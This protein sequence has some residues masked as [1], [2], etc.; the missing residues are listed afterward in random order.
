MNVSQTTSAEII[1]A[2]RWRRALAG[3]FDAAL[4]G[5]GTR[6]WRRR[7]PSAGARSTQWTPLLE[8][9]AQ[10]LRQQ[11]P[12]PGQLLFGLRTV[13]RRTGKREEL[14]RTL[15]VLGVGVAGRL[16]LHRIVAVPVMTPTQEHDQE[17]FLQELNAI[18]ERHPD[19]ALAREAER[20]RLFE[21]NRSPA[22]DYLRRAAVPMLTVGL[23]N[24]RLRRRLTPTLDIIARRADHKP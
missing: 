8:L 3:G 10:S 18:Q 6:L 4:V 22:F 19:D 11:L 1:P 13:D 20:R 16:L 5:A 7:P 9:A 21:R 17:T 24:N 12:S 14:W 23:L 2:P 15:V